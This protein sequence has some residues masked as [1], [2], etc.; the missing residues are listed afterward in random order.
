MTSSSEMGML[1]ELLEAAEGLASAAN[2][3]QAILS[4]TVRSHQLQS[5]DTEA[6]ANQALIHWLAKF[7]NARA[8][9]PALLS[10]IETL[11]AGQVAFDANVERLKACE[12]IAEGE[13]DWQVLRNVCPSAS[14]VAALRDRI[15]TLEEALRHIATLRERPSDHIVP[16]DWEQQIAD[17]EGCQRYKGHP[18]QQ[19]ICDTH[20]KPLYRREAYE[21]NE[22]AILGLRAREVAEMAL[23]KLKQPLV[24]ESRGQT[25]LYAALKNLVC[26]LEANDQDGLTE[27]ADEMIAARSALAAK[28]GG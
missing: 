16:A 28:S 6:V 23:A 21:K 14:A 5:D 15:E 24:T 1:R 4:I 13:K 20:R 2:M 10:R 19:G 7:D 25:A 17:C 11:E 9:A 8:R 27:F 3:A 22:T 26:A 18:I 12:Y